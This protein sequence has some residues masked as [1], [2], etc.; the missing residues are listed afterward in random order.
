MPKQSL[1]YQA[2]T[3][4][5]RLRDAQAE[6]EVMQDWSRALRIEEISERA[7]WRLLRR[8][9]NARVH[10]GSIVRRSARSQMRCH[11]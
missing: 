1:S 10:R 4:W 9:T 8:L 7:W 5:L 6:A 3:L 11:K 2:E